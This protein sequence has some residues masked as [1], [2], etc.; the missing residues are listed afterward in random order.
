MTVDALVGSLLD[1]AVRDPESTLRRATHLLDSGLDAERRGY[2]WQA[3]ALASG[4]RGEPDEALHAARQALT[5]A[6]RPPRVAEL[7]LLV[8][9]IEQD[10]GR[11]AASMRQ[12]DA[13]QPVLRGALLA[14]AHCLRG[15]NLCVAGDHR[16]AHRE[17]T[18]AITGLRRHA[19]EHWLGN[20]LAGR[21]VVRSYLLR[22][23]AAETDLADAE[24]LFA[25]LG[26]PE[27]AA[28][29][30]HNRGFVALQAGDLPRALDLFDQAVRAGLRVR[31]RAEALLDRA[32][33]MLAAGLHGDAGAVLERAAAELESAGRGLRC[34]DAFLAIGQC[35]LRAGRPDLAGAAARRA[36]ERFRAQR[37][38]AWLAVADSVVLRAGFAAGRAPVSEAIRLA[39][40]CERHGWPLD[41]AELRL[42]AAGAATAGRGTAR[43][44][45]RRVQA[46]RHT[47]PARLRALGWLAR[48]HLAAL[49]GKRVAVL[50]ACR[51]GLRVVDRSAAALGSPELRA[52]ASELAAGSAGTSWPTRNRC[53]ATLR[54]YGSRAGCLRGRGAPRARRRGWPP[55]AWTTR[56]WHRCAGCSAT[57]RWWWC[58]PAG[59]TACRGPRCRPAPGDRSRLR[60]QQ[61]PGLPRGRRATALP[62]A[63]RSGWPGQA[64][65]TQSARCGC[66]S[67]GSVARC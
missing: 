8:A 52:G 60:R 39:G 42:A 16:A 50:A 48:A 33:A 45:L 53:T 22:L 58:R 32:T 34:A 57:G 64:C 20:A 36:A 43:R 44:L 62:V 35:A 66:Y 26:E 56:C 15:L 1:T 29:C 13:A 18:V 65:G 31:E 19:D 55:S 38:T 7:R 28:T 23:A 40:R 54:R 59:C 17:L 37:R 14:R 25:G 46:H 4:E 51:A 12:L 24:R 47:G 3:I 6:E 63:R 5:L 10:R 27:R 9:W 30:R 2:V 67:A 49:D 61:R 21:G 11:T 41:A